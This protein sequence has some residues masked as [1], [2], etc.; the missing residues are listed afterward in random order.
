MTD[1]DMSNPFMWRQGQWLPYFKRLRDEAPVHFRASSE[2][3][4]YWSVTRYDDI[5]AVDKDFD[6]FSAAPQIIIGDPPE[7]LDIEMFIA[8]DPPKHDDQRKTVSPAVAPFQLAKLEPLIR[9]RAAKIL[10]ALKDPIEGYYDPRDVYTTVPRSSVLA[11]Y[12]RHAIGTGARGAL[13]GLRLGVIRE[14]MIIPP[15]S[16]TEQPIVSAATKEIKTV[17]GR[18]LGADHCQPRTCAVQ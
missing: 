17:L 5:V 12:A 16:K 6:T 8:M 11:S 9:E 13:K 3:G 18:H 1:I 14:S 7:G 4:P 15:G 10:D 2:F